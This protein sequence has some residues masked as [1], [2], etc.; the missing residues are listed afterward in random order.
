M[1]LSVRKALG[2]LSKAQLWE[3]RCNRPDDVDSRLDV[4]IHN[5][6]IAIQIQTSGRRSSWSE[7]TCIRYG[8]CVHQI[9]RPD[10][11]PLGSNARSLYM[12]ITCSG[13]ATVRTIGHHRPDAAQNRKELQRNS[14]KIDRTVVRPD[15][16]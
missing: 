12:E 2:F 9:N 10:D 5:G 11:H 16:P 14:Q 13:R 8:N 1:A 3:D 15:G 6:S 4:L 7:R